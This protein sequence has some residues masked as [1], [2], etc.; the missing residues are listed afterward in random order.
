LPIALPTEPSIGFIAF[1]KLIVRQCGDFTTASCRVRERSL[2]IVA[3]GRQENP[4][5]GGNKCLIRR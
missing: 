5:G 2:P 3:G 4:T 1:G